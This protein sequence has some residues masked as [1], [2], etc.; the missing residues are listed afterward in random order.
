MEL[1]REGRWL[2]FE[3]VLGTLTGADLIGWKLSGPAYA[4]PYCSCSARVYCGVSQDRCLALELG[5]Y[6][7]IHLI[8]TN[9]AGKQLHYTHER[10][11]TDWTPPICTNLTDE[12][13]FGIVAGDVDY[14][15]AIPFLR[16]SW[17]CWDPQSGVARIELAVGTFPGGDDVKEFTSVDGLSTADISGFP[18]QNRTRYYVTVKAINHAELRH[19][20][21][22]DGVLI[23]DTPPSCYSKRLLDG[24]PDVDSGLDANFQAYDDRL[25]FDWTDAAWDSDSFIRSEQVQWHDAM[26]GYGDAAFVTQPRPENIGCDQLFNTTACNTLQGCTWDMHSVRCVGARSRTTFEG[27]SL[28]HGKTYY[29]ILRATNNALMST[30][31]FTNGITVDKTPPTTGKCLDGNAM[32]PRDSS[33]TVQ[34]WDATFL[35]GDGDVEWQWKDDAL[36]PRFRGFSDPESGI[37]TYAVSV[38]DAFGRILQPRQQPEKMGSV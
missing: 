25:I 9:G 33:R 28:Q 8:V 37:A 14:V 21:F 20:M 1:L 12:D 31:C 23:D 18:V 36:F 30:D 11:M 2:C 3:D 19:T 22:T 32:M 15:S 27:L 29:G 10:I 24:R 38:E 7:N 17:S 5:E 13:P 4:E 6:Y 16:T 34:L 26:D 35:G